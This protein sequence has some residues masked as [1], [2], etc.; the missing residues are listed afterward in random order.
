M[1]PLFLEFPDATPDRSP[2][3]LTAGNE[4]LFGPDILVAPSPYPD[5]VQSYQVTFPPVPW[6][7]YW[8]GRQVAKAPPPGAAPL[9]TVA[10]QP[11]LATLPVYVRGGSVLPMQPLVQST[12]QTPH[13][14]LELRVYPGPDCHGSL[15]QDDGTTFNYKRGDYLRVD[16]TCRSAPGRFNL[17]IGRQEG[18]FPAWWRSIDVAVYNWPS[19]QVRARLNGRPVSGATYD[20]AQRVL[21]LRIPQSAAAQNL[22]LNTPARH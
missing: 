13:G 16:Y 17:H 9:Q 21:H 2:L 5:E 3:D 12:G 11:A 8:T 10:V 14:P 1:R 4:F 6:Y 19:A 15:Y 20:P 22:V 7:D 18:S